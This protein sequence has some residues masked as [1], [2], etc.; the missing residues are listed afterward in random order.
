MSDGHGSGLCFINAIK[1]LQGAVEDD[2]FTAAL[3]RT[4]LVRAVADGGLPAITQA[5]ALVDSIDTVALSR[6]MLD[7]AAALP[8][9]RLRTLDAI[10]LAAAQRAGTS[11]RAVVTYDDRMA[12]A[13]ATL[14]MP[15]VSPV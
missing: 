15:Y 3:A 1:A 10:H 9:P 13:A 11:L 12:E 8:P 7:D 6:S 5:R 4:E 14:G 2:L